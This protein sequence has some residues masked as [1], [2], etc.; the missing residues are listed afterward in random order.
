[1]TAKVTQCHPKWRDS[2][3]HILLYISNLW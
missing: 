2:M 1:M 3:V